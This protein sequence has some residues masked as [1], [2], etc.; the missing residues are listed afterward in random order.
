MLDTRDLV[1]IPQR[2]FLPAQAL[3]TRTNVVVD[4]DGH[5]FIGSVFPD[6][7]GIRVQFTV[8]GVHGE[9]PIGLNLCP[10]PLRATARV[11]DDCGCEVGPRPRWMTGGFLK[12]AGDGTSTLNW[13]LILESPAPDAGHLRLSFD[14]PAGDWVV[15]LP[16]GPIPAAG[17]PGRAISA[18][19]T[20]HGITLAAR[21][22]ARSDDLTAIELE[23]YLD[24]PSE[25]TGPSRRYVLGIGPCMYS[26]RLCGDQVVLRDDAGGRHLEI[27]RPCD[28]PVGGKRREAVTFPALHGDVRSGT[29]EVDVVWVQ[30][31]HDGT[32][33]VPV[34]GEADVTFAGCDGHV[35]TSRKPGAYTQ[36]SVSVEVTPKDP[37][38]DRQ[39]VF[40]GDVD[41]GSGGQAALGMNVQ[42]C[43]G[44]TPVVTVP[45]PTG[46]ATEV[47][48][49]GPVV[50]YRG[51]WRL[52]IPLE[53]N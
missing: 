38:A 40:C 20:K 17:V 48:L 29:V 37:D 27:G 47:K 53:T 3:G 26:G 22:V 51:P 31:G 30:E 32:V 35:V 50:Q 25:E 49:S 4:R 42:Q 11:V 1:F 2:G 28:E 13:T 21:A 45:E 39:L 18:S 43:V 12:D 7:D 15:E 36:G 8:S 46:T 44:K 6:R 14:G 19:E 24:P 5:T 34:P 52:E 9:T 41:A 16:L 33:T 10:L 23:A